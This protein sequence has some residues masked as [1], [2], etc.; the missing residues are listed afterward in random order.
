MQAL[1]SMA[2]VIWPPTIFSI[3]CRDFIHCQV[4]STLSGPY[5]LPGRIREIF[6]GSLPWVISG[7]GT[8]AGGAESPECTLTSSGG[9]QQQERDAALAARVERLE[10]A[11]APCGHAGQS[12]MSR[13]YGRGATHQLPPP[14][15]RLSRAHPASGAQSCASGTSDKTR[16]VTHGAASQ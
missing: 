6:G 1:K 10:A 3:G 5:R 15:W 11:A 4:V 14:P 13:Q 2:D 12:L 7:T 16:Y 8:G 9:P